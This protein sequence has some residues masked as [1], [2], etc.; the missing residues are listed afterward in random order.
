MV[1][2]AGT[3]PTDENTR[4]V[5]ELIRAFAGFL[6]SSANLIEAFLRAMR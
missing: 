4:T 6:R 2:K 3:G 1:E 5:E